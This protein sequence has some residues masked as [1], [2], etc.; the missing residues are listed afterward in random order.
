MDIKKVVLVTGA[1]KGIGREI[2]RQLSEHGLRVYLGARNEALGKQAATELSE[3]GSDVRFVRLDVTK[4]DSIQ[5]CAQT[6]KDDSGKLDVL[7]NNA[8]V[9]FEPAPPSSA[10]LDLIKKTFETNYFGA[11]ATAQKMLPLLR[12]SEFRVIVNVSSELGSLG[13]HGVP[14]WPYASFNF[15]AYNSSKTA[16]NAFTVLLAKELMAENFRVN[17]VNPGYTATDLTQF[18][19]TGTVQSAAAV[20]VK[21][22]L[23]GKDGPTGGFF[24]TGGSLPW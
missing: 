16:L 14:E 11:I 19:G 1:N 15:L 10:N 7:I 12:N 22:A 13:L 20:I 18:R 6:I 2:V 8:G 24:T 4:S 21:Y 5:S 17:S 9:N 23:V 3:G